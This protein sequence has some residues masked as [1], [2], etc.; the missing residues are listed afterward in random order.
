MATKTH[1]NN[2]Y[3]WLITDV[4]FSSDDDETGGFKKI[5]LLKARADIA[6]G[7][8]LKIY[9][10]ADPS[11]VIGSNCMF[12]NSSILTNTERSF[13]SSNFQQTYN[14]GSW[15]G[16]SN[17]F[18]ISNALTGINIP[19]SFQNEAV[20]GIQ[21]SLDI[22]NAHGTTFIPCTASTVNNTTDGTVVVQNSNVLAGPGLLNRYTV[23]FTLGNVQQDNTR[24]FQKLFCLQETMTVG[25]SGV[26]SVTSQ[27]T[28]Y[29]N[30]K[31]L[32]NDDLNVTFDC[33]LLTIKTEGHLL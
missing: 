2:Q 27:S 20:I 29:A 3:F 16:K 21:V 18:S 26:G 7:D 30:D 15:S 13:V 33:K 23:S 11:T 1:S 4:F 24:Y 28:Y 8:E 5:K 22:G 6:I 19:S 17:Q 31:F 32:V 25:T 10:P 9:D 12:V 14:L